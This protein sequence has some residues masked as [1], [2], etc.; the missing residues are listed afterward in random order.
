MKKL[1][2][3]LIGVLLLIAFSTLTFAQKVV[4]SRLPFTGTRTFCGI[5]QQG[6]TAV[7]CIRE[8]GFTTVKTNM[9][10]PEVGESRTFRYITFSGTLNARGILRRNRDIYLQVKSPREIEMIAPQ[11]YITGKL[12][13]SRELPPEQ[14][15]DVQRTPA[16]SPSAGRN[17]EP[18]TVP[19]GNVEPA[20]QLA[21]NSE[22][23]LAL[24]E[25]VRKYGG[26]YS[27]DCRK[28]SAY[29][30]NIAVDALTL[31]LGSKQ[32]RG[33]NPTLGGL[34][35]IYKDITT[36][37]SLKAVFSADVARNVRMSFTVYNDK[38]GPYL[39][40]IGHRKIEDAVQ[41]DKDADE[42]PVFR[43]CR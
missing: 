10:G 6:T 34:L 43:K 31:K 40:V 27:V 21:P 33:A 9:W 5:E 26:T 37:P 20:I 19:V 36:D 16:A 30:A 8:D 25:M 13:T 1:V 15:K 14:R 7:V 38:D 39:L 2:P 4:P 3:V 35:P 18:D 23:R 41:V 42:R 28:L 12:C 29:Q 17:R 24:E 32:I 11:D 22:Q